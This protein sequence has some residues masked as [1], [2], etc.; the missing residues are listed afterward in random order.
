MPSPPALR[1]DVAAARGAAGAI[2]ELAEAPAASL[3]QP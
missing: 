2:S 1:R 3:D